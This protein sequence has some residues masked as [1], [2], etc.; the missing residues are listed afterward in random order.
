[1]GKRKFYILASIVTLCV[2]TV[3]AQVEVV[4][5]TKL[6]PFGKSDRK[7]QTTELHFERQGE[8]AA[9]RAKFDNVSTSRHFLPQR[10]AS[11]DPLVS[12]NDIVDDGTRINFNIISWYLGQLG[13]GSVR[14]CANA[15][16]EMVHAL[17]SSDAVYGILPKIANGV[18]IDGKYY[19][20]KYGTA[21]GQVLNAE[22][23][24]FDAETWEIEASVTLPAQWYSIFSGAAYN[25][26]DGKVY[27]LGYDGVARPYL[28]ELNLTTGVYTQLVSCSV[29]VLSMA[30]DADGNLYAFTGNGEIEK[31]DIATG[32]GTVVLRALEAGKST[33]YENPIAFDYRTGELF[34]FNTDE[35]FKTTLRKIDLEK[36]TVELVADLSGYTL[37]RVQG[38]WVKSPEAADKAPGVVLAISADFEAN[39]TMGSIKVVAP[40]EAFDGTPLTGDVTLKVSVDGN[41]VGQTVVAAGAEGVIDGCNFGSVGEHKISVVASNA[42]GD[43]P[44][45]SI[46]AYCGLDTPCPA[47]NV[48]LSVSADGKATLAWDAPTRGVHDG[49]FDSEMLSYDIVRNPGNISVAS[50]LSAESFAETLPYELDR[51]SYAVT[52]SMAGNEGEP[53]VSNS[54]VYG[55]GYPVP[56][57]TDLGADPF[58]G[59]C[60]IFD[61]DGDG[62]TFYQTWGMA[63]C[64]I[65]YSDLPHTS[66]DWLISAPVY[67]EAG[68]YFY[69]IKYMASTDGVD[70][71]FTMGQGNTPEHQTVEIA[72][73]K[74]LLYAEGIKTTWAYVSAKEPGNY[75]FGIHYTPEIPG[76]TTSM[77]YGN[78]RSLKIDLGPDD[79]APSYVTEVKAVAYTKGELKTVLTFKAPA[80]TF[81]GQSLASISKIE[82]CNAEDV[83][84]GTITDAQPGQECTFTDN[85]C[86]QGTNLYHIYAYNEKGKGALTEVSVYA[87]NDAPGMVSSIDWSIENNRVLTF[88]WGAPS[89]VGRNGG[90]VDPDNITYDFCRSQFDYQEP[91][92]VSGGSNLKER[93][94]TYTECGADSYYGDT[95]HTYFYGI[96]P[97]NTL[98]DGIMGYVGIV[99]GAPYPAPFGESFAGGN[100]KSV[101]WSTQL[102]DGEAAFSISTGNAELGITPSDNDNGM[103]LFDHE[104]D[105]MTGQAVVSPIIELKDLKSPT[106]AFDLW[107][108]SSAGDDAYLSIQA[109]KGGR[110]YK[111]IGEVIKINDGKGTDGWVRHYVS[112]NDYNNSDRVFVAFLGVNSTASSYFAIDD[113][114]VYD[115]VE[116]DLAAISLTAP[117]KMYINEPGDFV[118][119]VVSRGTQDVAAYN[120]DIYADGALVATAPG[121]SLKRGESTDVTVRVTPNAAAAGKTVIYEAR[122]ALSADGNELNDS[123]TATVEVGG[124]S[125]PAPT[126]LQGV[127]D[128]GTIDLSWRAP[129][130]DDPA[131]TTE[132]WEGYPAFAISS[133]GDWQFVDGDHLAPCGIGGIS[134][135]NMDKGRAFMIWNPASIKFNDRAWQPLSGTQCLIAFASDYY[136]ENGIYDGTQQS[137]EWLISPH[138]VGGTTVSFQAASPAAGTTERFEFLISYGSRNIDDF[139]TVG[140]EVLVT[141][142]G[143]KQYSYTLPADA[144]YFA[145]RYV[146]KGYEAFAMLF[147]DIAYTPG[148]G[149][150]EFLG[151][152][153]YVNGARINDEPLSETTYTTYFVST[154]DNIYGVSAVYD[155]GESDMASFVVKSGIETIGDDEVLVSGGDGCIIVKKAEG[156]LISVY[157]TMGRLVAQR[158]GSDSESFSVSRQSVYIVRIG[159][160]SYKVVVK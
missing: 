134:Y 92:A 42:V 81:A 63:S 145:I 30:C 46:I 70:A 54:V 131:E 115:D 50:N 150:F 122:I 130:M 9:S 4:D 158:T 51:Y 74:N 82:I 48:T 11:T 137:D 151:Y 41:E 65:A 152:N 16:L 55:P 71:T 13:I 6:S 69:Q 64:N 5:K 139:T 110:S 105:V 141:E 38:P 80:T 59:L 36:Q 125:L 117:S 121:K 148:Y 49:Y 157:D 68:N 84:V 140:E 75:Y 149:E 56:F 142:T 103:L 33:G 10:I 98:G 14:P 45:G 99:C 87:G 127:A 85:N 78:F 113:I 138:V 40:S 101:V 20:L 108:N 57:E 83:L 7:E 146:S 116:I 106:L 97:K 12:P 104:H 144:Q 2:T 128:N 107:H 86:S 32:T 62:A 61:L 17:Q 88:E 58:F 155:Q 132:S 19:G 120:I 1:M 28:S 96:L 124:S 72:K 135:P 111:P 160:K 24:K 76:K 3:F 39:S 35:N 133:Q 29:S 27:V 43:G 123:A 159:G 112:L 66:D 136:T 47:E 8:A 156:R 37:L 53:A 22:F 147:D 79:G 129:I 118:A 90:Y 18:Y 73:V 89:T 60:N 67:L 126:Y 143:W 94:F 95:Q 91:F 15:S 154:I 34:W 102:L 26:K 52:V 114:E 109:S 100:N 21:M 23:Y 31:I 77:P 93:T 25:P 119:R 44:A 153:I